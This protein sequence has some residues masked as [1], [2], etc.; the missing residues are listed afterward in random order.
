[1]VKPQEYPE[2]GE[3]VVCTVR[4][5]KGFGAFVLLDEYPGKEGFIHITEIAPGWIKHIRDYVRERQK[6]VCKV[7]RVDPTKGHIDLSLKQVNDHQRREK[8]KQWMCEQKAEKLFEIVCE[9]AK[10]DLDKAIANIGTKLVDK[11]GSLY[12]A[13]EAATMDPSSFKEFKG[14]WVKHFIDIAKENIVPPYVEIEGVIT[15]RSLDVKGVLHIKNALKTVEEIDLPPGVDIKITYLGSPKYRI[16]VQ[17]PDYKTAE[18]IMKTAV[19]KIQGYMKS[20][21]GEFNF[22][23][24]CGK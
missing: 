8:I 4:T 10:M 6:I 11:F 7:I 5:V 24:K 18:A 20:I 13:F 15:L 17:A 16:S 2:T 14:K 19:D 21:K 22:E 3:F 12:A 1:M 23:R 9:R